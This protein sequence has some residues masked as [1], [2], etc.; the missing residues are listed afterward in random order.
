MPDFHSLQEQFQDNLIRLKSSKQATEPKPFRLHNQKK[1]A[2][3]PLNLLTHTPAS[4]VASARPRQPF[5][6]LIVRKCEH[7]QVLKHGDPNRFDLSPIA[8]TV[9]T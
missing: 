1:C 9:E 7:A 3:L 4:R 6:Y 5:L 2:L 8:L